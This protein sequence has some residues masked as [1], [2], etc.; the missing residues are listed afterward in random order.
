MKILSS[1]VGVDELSHVAAEDDEL[2]VHFAKNPWLICSKPVK[3]TL[4]G[5]HEAF[6]GQLIIIIVQKYYD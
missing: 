2:S 6:M 4:Y 1:S 5:T 3:L